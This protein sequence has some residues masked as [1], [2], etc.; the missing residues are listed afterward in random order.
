LLSLPS[1]K[2]LEAGGVDLDE[3]YKGLTQ[4]LVDESQRHEIRELTEDTAVLVIECL[5]RVSEIRSCS[6]FQRFT[7]LQIISSDAFKTGSDFQTRSNIFSTISRLSRRCQHLPNS[8]WI[9]PGTISLPDMAHTS[10]TCAAIYCG[11]RND[12]FVAVKILRTSSLED[13]AQLKKVCTGDGQ[14][15][16]HV[17]TG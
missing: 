6:L 5:D 2:Q 7:T 4:A 12:E 14:R 17:G 13:P 9:N 11:K 1:A 10:G 15:A 3:L 16:Q 8:Y